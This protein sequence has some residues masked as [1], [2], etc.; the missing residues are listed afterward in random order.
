MSAFQTAMAP[1]KARPMNLRFI[2]WLWN[3]R[4]SVPLAPGQSGDEAFERLAPL[5]REYGTRT[6]RAGNRLEFTKKDAAA[7]DKLAVFDAGVIEI[8]EGGAKGDSGAELRYRL[9]S[10]SLLFCLLAPLMF[11]AFAGTNIAL[12]EWK[13]QHEVT[14]EKKAEKPKTPMVLNPIDKFLG[15][16]EPDKDGPGKVKRDRN[17]PTPAYVFAGIFVA[18]F[19]GGRVL[20]DRLVKSLFRKRLAGE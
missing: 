5:F 3:V 18:L 1:A 20:E 14:A 16:P 2:D 17:S 4:G 19:F 9:F 15:A 6:E 10:K 13:K 11:L 7:Q 8:A 12:G